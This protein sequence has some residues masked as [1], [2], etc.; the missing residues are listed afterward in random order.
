MGIAELIGLGVSTVF[1]AIYSVVGHEM[2]TEIFVPNSTVDA[3]FAFF[4]ATRLSPL[5]EW[6]I[7]VVFG[8]YV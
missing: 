2:V 1:T 3:G 4:L 8:F 6:S 7:N 5:R